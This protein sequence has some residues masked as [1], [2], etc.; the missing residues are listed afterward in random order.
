M[1][2]FLWLFALHTVLVSAITYASSE[3]PLTWSAVRVETQKFGG[4]IAEASRTDDGR[5]SSLSISVRGKSVELGEE[6]LPT[7]YLVYLNDLKISY[8]EF[9]KEGPYWDLSFGVDFSGSIDGLGKYHLI[10]T[11]AG[12]H[13]SY[14][15]YAESEKVL[16]FSELCNF[17]ADD[18]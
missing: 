13:N 8:G 4:A 11:Q 3:I 10:M 16:A 18:A 17:A 1:K 9:T 5:L 2:L 7:K 15:E 14:I 12:V 6:C